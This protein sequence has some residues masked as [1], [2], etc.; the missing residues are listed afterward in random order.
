MF[1]SYS[2]SW[3]SSSKI[4]YLFLLSENKQYLGRIILYI[5]LL[6]VANIFYDVCIS[7]GFFS[8][9]CMF[10]YF[11]RKQTIPELFWAFYFFWLP[12]FF[13]MFCTII[14]KEFISKYFTFHNYLQSREFFNSITW[15]YLFFYF[16]PWLKS[17]KS[18]KNNIFLGTAKGLLAVKKQKLHVYILDVN[19]TAFL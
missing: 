18:Y 19:K 9:N 5:L 6:L 12:I 10:I 17:Y 14:S 2:T 11:L 1:H 4:A 15:N 7:G 13:M 16:W 8:K 3:R